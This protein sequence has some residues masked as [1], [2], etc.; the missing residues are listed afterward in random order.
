MA[1]LKDNPIYTYMLQCA[2]VYILQYPWEICKIRRGF[3]LKIIKDSLFSNQI[4]IN[5]VF[6]ISRRDLKQTAR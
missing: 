6:L 3:L 5:K 2:Y 4:L 1:S